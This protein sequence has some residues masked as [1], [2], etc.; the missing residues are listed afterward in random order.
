MERGWAK[1]WDLSVVKPKAN[2][3]SDKSQYSAI[4]KFNNNNINNIIN[5]KQS[6]SSFFDKFLWEAA[7]FRQEQ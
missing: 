3:W 5:N 6:P 1:Y 4:T 2:D 7:I